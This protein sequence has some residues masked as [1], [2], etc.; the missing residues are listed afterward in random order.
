MGAVID[1]RNCLDLVAR[2]N[3]DLLRN[4]YDLFVELR[5]KS[6]LPIP[7]NLVPSTEDQNVLLLRFLDCAVFRYLHRTI[8]EG[9]D[10]LLPPFDT[11]RGL[12]TEGGEAFPGS[13]IAAKSHIQIAV[14]NDDCIRGLFHPLIDGK[15]MFG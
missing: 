14:C 3:V 7:K 5:N 10:P 8:R 9:G 6:K 12:F 11:V 1:L 2:E 15:R 13:G 4:A